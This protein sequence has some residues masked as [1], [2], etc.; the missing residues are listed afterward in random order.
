[1]SSFRVVR[2]ALVA[3][4]ILVATASLARAQAR[5]EVGASLVSGTIGF[6]DDL[7]ST[8]GVPSGGLGVLSPG[9]Y[10]SFFLGR[11]LAVEPQLGLVWISLDGDSAYLL[12]VVGQFDYF[13]RGTGGSSPY[14]F[15]AAGLVDSTDGDAVTSLG[16]GAG[17][18]LP[19][20]DR[21][22]FRVDGRYTHFLNEFD[23]SDALTFTLSIGGL[24]GR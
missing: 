20:G 4:A 22:A 24:F 16:L 15:G 9:V 21:L 6:G 17:Y 5:A 18:R 3:G 2:I 14:V 1:M 12:N 10:A 7:V 11:H 23:G 8:I 19:V 13:V